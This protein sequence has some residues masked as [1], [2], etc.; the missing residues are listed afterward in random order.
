[1][2]ITTPT[3]Q[4]IPSQN[5]A[6]SQNVNSKIKFEKSAPELIILCGP[7]FSGKTDYYFRNFKESHKRISAIELFQKNPELS[8]RQII[9]QYLIN[10]LKSGFNVVIDDTNH[11]STIRH[12]YVQAIIKSDITLSNLVVYTFRPSGG[13][14]QL[15]WNET[16]KQC[17]MSILNGVN[18]SSSCEVTKALDLNTYK[19]EYRE[20]NI[21]EGFC[22]LKEI[23]AP[24]TLT[25]AVSDS[26]SNCSGVL[27]EEFSNKALFIDVRAIMEFVKNPD[28]KDS[29]DKRYR[30]QLFDQVHEPMKEWLYAGINRRILIFIDET[31]LFPSSL[32]LDSESHYQ[33]EYRSEVKD[34]VKDLS[35]LVGFPIY[36]LL[37][38]KQVQDE[39]D[40][41][42][43]PNLGLF[44]WAQYRH[45]ISMSASTFIIDDN[46]VK[47]ITT[48][49][50]NVLLASKFFQQNTL[51]K[52]ENKI[53]N[54][55]IVNT[56]NTPSFLDNIVISY[57]SERKGCFEKGFPLYTAYK[58]ELVNQSNYVEECMSMNKCH[59]VFFPD[60]VMDSEKQLVVV[61]PQQINSQQ[62]DEIEFDM[63]DTTPPIVTTSTT[64][65]TTTT[66]TITTTTTMVDGGN[67]GLEL[68]F[69]TQEIMKEWGI[70][71]L[72][73]MRGYGYFKENRL[74]DMEISTFQTTNAP[75]S[76]KVFSKITGTSKEPYSVYV[77]Y[78]SIVNSND[79]QESDTKVV[80]GDDKTPALT[81][82][83]LPIIE[84]SCSCPNGVRTYGKCKHVVTLIYHCNCSYAQEPPKVKVQYPRDM[85]PSKSPTRKL[86]KWMSDPVPDKDK[87]PN[88]RTL[89]LYFPENHVTSKQH[90]QQPLQRRGKPEL[91]FAPPVS[92][93]TNQ[94]NNNSISPVKKQ[95]SFQPQPQYVNNSSIPKQS[96]FGQI[97][98]EDICEMERAANK[99]RNDDFIKRLFTDQKKPK[100][101]IDQTDDTEDDINEDSF[102]VP[103]TNSEN[104]ILSILKIDQQKI[105][106][107]VIKYDPP[108]PSSTQY[109]HSDFSLPDNVED[110]FESTD[111]E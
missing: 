102:E 18:S 38:P 82:T 96:S 21:S 14:Q 72:S 39:H 57:D 98:F 94:N 111:E 24:L 27:D 47:F 107:A 64:T 75:P 25:M 87:S 35:N 53:L 42:R 8:I 70:D 80:D 95:K 110:Y 41:F 48:L 65:T 83:P 66:S 5:N 10:Y 90:Q 67:G 17:E 97:D 61:E 68:T 79:K 92:N 12:T 2:N 99:Q 30:V 55:Q 31:S 9:Q 62:L 51:L 33:S 88:K 40:F 15:F 11:L 19:I 81:K 69:I 28:F 109:L 46:D 59:G 86:P 44:A 49:P 22:Y 23:T 1:M 84:T 105:R 106:D 26:I 56:S 3:K 74:F 93:N 52:A 104:Q 54:H 101:I 60:S 85:T 4:Y 7:C 58:R 78:R 36:Y 6:H 76:V 77:K 43:I 13:E 37:C 73:I 63:D 16:W 103:R 91:K 45:R 50:F 100:R 89:N 20:P 71:D 34:C 108:S 32:D 29:S